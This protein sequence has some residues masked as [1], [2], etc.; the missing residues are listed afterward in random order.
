MLDL[1]HFFDD[2][3]EEASDCVVWKVREMGSGFWGVEE[4]SQSGGFEYGIEFEVGFG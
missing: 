1:A 2:P 4:E 3:G